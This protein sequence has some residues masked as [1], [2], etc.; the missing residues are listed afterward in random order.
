MTTSTSATDAGLAPNTTFIYKVIAIG[1]VTNATSNNDVATTIQWQ[2]TADVGSA[3]LS[4]QDFSELR[5]GIDYVRVAAGK[6]INT[7]AESI[8]QITPLRAA[9]MNE[10]R[11][12]LEEALLTI[13]APLPSYQYPDPVAGVSL[14][15]ARDVT[16]L[17]DK[18]H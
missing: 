7:W 15:R 14:I 12:K 6:P 16:D 10:M 2:S 4:A 9:H 3:V 8:D 1:S 11:D 18:V 5:R 17:R 13:G